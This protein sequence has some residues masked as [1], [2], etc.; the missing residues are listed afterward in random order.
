MNDTVIAARPWRTRRV[1][2]SRINHAR[3]LHL[4]AG[5]AMHAGSESVRLGLRGFRRGARKRV[6]VARAILLAE[7]I[8][9]SGD[10]IRVRPAKAVR[11]SCGPLRSGIIACGWRR[12]GSPLMILRTA[13]RD[14]GLPAFKKSWTTRA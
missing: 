1:Q 13:H 14:Y 10:S 5:G 2:Y 3:N 7:V 11:F 4:S 9:Y 12:I 8:C 6:M